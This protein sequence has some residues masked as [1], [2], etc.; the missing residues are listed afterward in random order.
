MLT[1]RQSLSEPSFRPL[2]LFRPRIRFVAA[3][4][5]GCHGR[6]RAD[7][8]KSSAD[9][10]NLSKQHPRG[11]RLCGGGWRAVRP[12]FATHAVSLTPYEERLRKVSERNFPGLDEVYRIGY[13][14]LRAAVE[15]N[16]RNGIDTHDVTDLFN[17]RPLGEEIYL[18]FSHLA[19]TGDAKVADTV[20]RVEFPDLARAHESSIKP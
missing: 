16:R 18:D 4:A 20:F 13:P 5:S 8:R 10:G 2:F 3:K 11:G 19:E 1:R 14:A 9:P 15:D 7:C 17:Q 12:L 6:S